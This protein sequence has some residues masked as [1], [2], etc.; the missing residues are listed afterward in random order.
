MHAYVNN[1]EKVSFRKD[2]KRSE[3]QGK[4]GDIPKQYAV[5]PQGVPL[6]A[7]TTHSQDSNSGC[8]C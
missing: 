5:P 6:K 3:F 7:T 1:R 8:F 4:S 2:C